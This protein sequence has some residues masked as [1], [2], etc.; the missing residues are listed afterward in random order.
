MLVARISFG[1]VAAVLCGVIVGAMWLWS[2]ARDLPE[3]GTPPKGRDQTS[4]ITDR[5]GE[6]IAKLFAEQNRTDRALADIPVV[7]RQAVISTEDQR[8]Y[9]HKGVDPFGVARALWVDV[10][11]GKSHGGSTITQQYVKT[12]FLSP[13]QTLSRKVK[14][15]LFAYRVENEL[16]KD[17]I[18]ELYLNTIYFG[19]GAYGVEAAS[20]AYFGSTVDKLTLAQSAVLAGVIKSPGRYSPYLEPEAGKDRRDTV[21]SQ[22]EEQ[23]YI[24]AEESKAAQAEEITLA[25]LAD[26][27]AVAPY[28]TEYVKA[29]LVDTYGADVV[30]RGGI[31]VRTTL[32]LRLQRIAEKAVADTLDE[33]DDPSAALV[34]L[35]P[36]T[37]EILAMVGG[38]DFSTQQFNVAVQGRRQPGSAFKPFVLLSA[39]E[40]GVS[41][42]KPFP[43]AAA[44]F[45]LDNGQVWKVTGSGGGMMRLRQ[46][47]EKS[48]NSVFARLILDTGPEKTVEM[49][50]RLGIRKGID[51]VPAVALG[52]LE[53]GVSPLEMASAYGT[54]AAGGKHTVPYGIAEVADD[55]GTVLH[56]GETSATQAITPALAYVASDILTGVI[57]SGTGKSAAIGR[58]AAGKTGT[59]QEYRDAWFVGYT[60]QLVAAVWVGYPDAQTEMKNVHGV[61]VT[62][63]SFPAKIWSRFMKGAL[64]SAPKL[65]FVKPKGV[66]NVSVCSE[67]GLA[68]TDFCPTTVSGLFLDKHTPGEC[69]THAVPLKVSIPNVIGMTKEAALAAFQKLFLLFKVL[70]EDVPGVAAGIVAK[71]DPVAGSEGTTETVVTITVSNGGSA[72][73]PPK[74]DF[75]VVPAEGSAGSGVTFDASASTDDSAIVKY[76]WEFG[77]GTKAEGVTQSHV[78]GMPGTFEVTLWV[79]DD[80]GQTS[81][82]TKSLTVR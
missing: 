23:G 15:A 21:L 14:E 34:A 8:Y 11:Q 24:T 73:L 3:P 77:D 78:F 54:L 64:E 32:D 65:E 52:G 68:A 82:V 28:F 30:Y 58:P 1:V 48:V 72:D 57:T 25:G 5:N 13:E 39:L 63:G 19:H 51:P 16:T 74:A 44:S 17:Q 56:S 55:G 41:S 36:V 9:L 47:T 66:V 38:R 43:A 71:Q 42:E 62:G 45:N 6:T 27:N 26:G 80:K 67:T 61:A 12:A 46:A 4:V 2:L 69:S 33:P 37:G 49:A 22:M 31:S 18:L 10:T 7:L 70:E 79:T 60:P 50:E 59:T 40:Q 81:S 29:R 20:Q 75:T 76:L 53:Q 35:N